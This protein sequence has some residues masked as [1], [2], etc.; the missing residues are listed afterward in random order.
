ML[1]SI[2]KETMKTNEEEEANYNFDKFGK[3]KSVFQSM[4]QFEHLFRP[5]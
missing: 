2:E 5:S 4:K 3:K 1:T